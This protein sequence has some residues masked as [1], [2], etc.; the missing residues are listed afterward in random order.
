MPAV[1]TRRET[2]DPRNDCFPH[3]LPFISQEPHESPLLCEEE[4]RG[5]KMRAK[6]YRYLFHKV[7]E[8]VCYSGSIRNQ[9]EEEQED[10]CFLY[11]AGGFAVSYTHLTLPTTPYV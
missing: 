2:A 6:Y 7:T 9:M 10:L 11:L 3:T 5:G 1:N 8:G 4:Q